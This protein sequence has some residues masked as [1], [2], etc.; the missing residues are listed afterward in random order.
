[1]T[2]KSDAL[3]GVACSWKVTVALRGALL[4]VL[5]CNEQISGKDNH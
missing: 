1:V 5:G 2:V 4:L 3:F